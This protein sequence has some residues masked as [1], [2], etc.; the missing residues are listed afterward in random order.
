MAD[1]AVTA[2]TVI[3]NC[4]SRKKDADKSDWDD[5][6]LLVYLNKAIYQIGMTLI[7]LENELA[8]TDA[9]VTLVLDTQEYLFAH[10]D[11][12]MDDFWA[13]SRE[14]VFF[15]AV[16]TPL[17]PVLYGDKIR[18]KT[19]TTATYPTKYYI[20]NDSIG[21]IPIPTTAATCLGA[22]L[23]CRYFKRPTTLVLGTSMP[24]GNIFNEVASMFMDS[25]AALREEVDIVAYK[26]EQANLETFV[27]EVVKYRNPI[28]PKSLPEK[29]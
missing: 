16:S 19:T 29:G 20:T 4:I 1:T 22:T 5:A 15:D 3:D 17:P 12:N 27:M 7:Y 23:K 21:L 6:E 9:T 11:T 2:Q 14:G 26:K 25:L 10:A 28:G 18:N 13:M 8:I 24:Y